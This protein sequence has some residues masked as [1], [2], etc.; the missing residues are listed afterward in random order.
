MEGSLATYTV[1][2]LSTLPSANLAKYLKQ[3]IELKAQL[4]TERDDYKTKNQTLET[5]NQTLENTVKE[6]DNQITLANKRID[7]YM[8]KSALALNAFIGSSFPVSGSI[9]IIFIDVYDEM[10]ELLIVEYSNIY[11]REEAISRANQACSMGV[12]FKALSNNEYF[13]NE[14]TAMSK[15]YEFKGGATK[16]FRAFLSGSFC[17]EFINNM[18]ETA[19]IKGSKDKTMTKSQMVEMHDNFISR[20]LKHIIHFGHES[21]KISGIIKNLE[22]TGSPQVK[23]TLSGMYAMNFFAPMLSTHVN[24]GTVKSLSLQ[25]LTPIIRMRIKHLNNQLPSDHK[26]VTMGLFDEYIIV[27]SIKRDYEYELTKDQTLNFYQG[28]IQMLEPYYNTTHT[29][30]S[31]ILEPFN[32][33]DDEIERLNDYIIDS[34]IWIISRAQE[35]SN[36]PFVPCLYHFISILMRASTF[37]ELICMYHKR[38]CIVDKEQV[39]K[40]IESYISHLRLLFLNKWATLDGGKADAKGKDTNRRITDYIETADKTFKSIPAQGVCILKEFAT[41][42]EDGDAFE[43]CTRYNLH[44]NTNELNKYITSD[45]QKVATYPEHYMAGKKEAIPVI[46]SNQLYSVKKATAGLHAAKAVLDKD[47]NVLSKSHAFN[48][49]DIKYLREKVLKCANDLFSKH[50]N[51]Y[52]TVEDAIKDVKLDEIQMDGYYR[53]FVLGSAIK[54]F[55]IHSNRFSIEEDMRIMREYNPAL[56]KFIDDLTNDIIFNDSLSAV[57]HLM[58]CDMI[59]QEDMN[60]IGME[61]NG[62]N[63]SYKERFVTNDIPS[64]LSPDLKKF[65]NTCHSRAL[66]IYQSRQ[67]E[68]EDEEEEIYIEIEEEEEYEVPN[69]IMEEQ[70]TDEFED[71]EIANLNEFSRVDIINDCFFIGIPPELVTDPINANYESLFKSYIGHIRDLISKYLVKTLYECEHT[72]NQ[73]LY[74][75]LQD[76]LAHQVSNDHELAKLESLPFVQYLERYNGNMNPLFEKYIIDVSKFEEKLLS[77]IISNPRLMLAILVH[78]STNKTSKACVVMSGSAKFSFEL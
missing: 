73:S 8:D 52:K 23:R 62:D 67:E 46:N 42:V 47:G 74:E 61:V 54:W 39:T 4:E 36:M 22:K 49:K 34:F 20:M 7:N 11:T 19:S 15:E 12:V 78:R 40:F 76:P 58:S 37:K 51:K 66:D 6:K 33:T 45:N 43:S 59:S 28:L 69:F 16:S 60:A 70:L 77:K 2:Q 55:N 56:F 50:P 25:L 64:D 9:L 31:D 44:H 57:S 68:E 53:D 21:G 72:F 32:P 3:Y 10:L 26:L 5:K 18:G 17:Q 71:H 38:Y 35:D 13:S 75:R 30:I 65:L 29:Q 41:L 1:E 27:H 63:Y 14:L 48:D 24:F